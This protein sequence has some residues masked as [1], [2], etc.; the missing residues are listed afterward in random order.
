LLWGV[1]TN[2]HQRFTI[3]LSQQMDLFKTA[4]AVVSGDTMVGDVTGL[5]TLTVHVN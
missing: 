2:K 3:P 1:V 4:G 5:P